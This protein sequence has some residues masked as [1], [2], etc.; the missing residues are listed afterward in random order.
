MQ[1]DLISGHMELLCKKALIA[2]VFL[3][4]VWSVSAQQTMTGPLEKIQIIT[5]RDNYVT[6]E[7]VWFKLN[8]FEAQSNNLLTF[9]RVAYVE[10]IGA[11]QKPVLQAKVNLMR[12][13]GDG[14]FA[15]PASINTGLYTLRAYTNWMKNWEPTAFAYH[16]L[17]IVNVQRSVKVLQSSVNEAPV[18]PNPGVIFKMDKTTYQTRK[19]AT[20]SL[21]MPVNARMD[22]RTLSLVIRSIDS[23]PQA[24]PVQQLTRL[25]FAEAR[26]QWLPEIEGHIITAIVTDRSSGAPAVKLPVTLTI[27]GQVP[28]MISDTTD[29]TGHAIF[30]VTDFIGSESLIL[31]SP[32]KNNNAFRFDLLSPFSDQFTNESSATSESPITIFPALLKRNVNAQAM[33]I[34][35]SHAQYMLPE[36]TDTLSFYGEPD[37]RY[38][39]D[40]YTRFHTMEEVLREYVRDVRLRKD[41]DH[42]E[43]V[44]LNAP[45]KSFF[46]LQ[47][48]IVYDGL[49][50][51]NTDQ[52]IALDPLKIQRIDV[53]ENQF[54]HRGISHSGLL[55]ITSYTGNFPGL[56]LDSGAQV[57]DY[58][59]IQLRKR[60]DQPQYQSVEAETS[61][62]PDLRSVLLWEPNLPLSTA[63]KADIR[64]YTSDVK[65]QFEAIVRGV[66]ERNQPFLQ[67]TVFTVE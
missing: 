48:L 12:G 50:I 36:G 34:F 63:G 13:V 18:S 19:L 66:D 3:F 16:G 61:R 4:I 24:L 35:M 51:A 37:K 65:G 29:E 49:V 56:Q 17:N 62:L 58:P 5:D 28:Q 67:K 39:L 40:D 1:K 42:Y 9:S 44:T 20:L 22:E 55:A 26:V 57:F 23:L 41:R 10:L 46:E 15:L 25:S 30:V 11:D 7:Q 59:A 64:F 47:P 6:G 45:F 21:G 8:D 53:I 2:C 33:N 14:V 60:F 43:V 52:L 38:W 27:T 31:E 32:G 54:V